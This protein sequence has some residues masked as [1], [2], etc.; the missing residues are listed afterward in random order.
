MPLAHRY[1]TGLSLRANQ[2]M[3]SAPYSDA[4]TS[5]LAALE[6]EPHLGRLEAEVLAAIRSAGPRGLCDHEIEA[7]TGLLHQTASARRRGLVLRGAVTDSG[8]RR[9]TP[10]G[11]LAK[12]WV[13]AQ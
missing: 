9:P 2:P 4:Q 5:L 3:R 8:A 7:A 6:I 12:V 1:W 10:S 13:V 11:R